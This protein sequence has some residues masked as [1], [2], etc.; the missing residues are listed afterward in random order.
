LQTNKRPLWRCPGGREKGS[1]N[2]KTIE[3]TLAEH[4]AR[5]GW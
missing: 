4:G 1:Q 2:V 5:R 3:R